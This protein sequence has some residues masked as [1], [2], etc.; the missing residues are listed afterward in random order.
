MRRC[1]FV[2]L[3]LSLG[4]RALGAAEVTIVIDSPM[5]PPAWALLEQQLLRANS[6]A[7]DFFFNK[8]VDERGYLL[9]TP[10]WGTI[11]DGPDDAIETFYNWTL[12]HALGG[13]DSVLRNFKKALDGHLLQYKEVKSTTTDVAKDGSYSKEFIV[14][15][16]WGHTGEGTR[17]FMLQGLS[18]PKD[19]V[20]R[21]RMRRFAGMYM[22]EDPD[23]QNYDPQHKV[24]K[25]IWNGSKGPMLR[26]ATKDDWVGDPIS[27]RFHMLHSKA[28][29][30][31]M[32]DFEEHYPKMLAHVEEYLDSAGDH[33]RNLAATNLALN[34]Y[35]LTHA[36]KYKD[37]L[38]EYVNAW[39][40][41][42]EANGGN[43]PTNVGLDGTLGGEH[44]GRW[45][46]GVYGW[47]FTIYDGEIER[48]DH[49]GGLPSRGSW[50][51]FGNALLLTGDQAYVDTLRRQID[52]L[53]AQQKVVDDKITVPQMY[54]D[55][56]GYRYSGPGEWYHW[57]PN[58]PVDEMTQIYLWSMD[59]KDLERIPKT[60]WVGFL[61]GQNPG[62]PEQA[63]AEDLEELRSRMEG[64]R[65][66]PTTPDTRLADWLQTG[67]SPAQTNALT[68]LMLGGYLST[69]RIWTLHS[70]VR[71]FDPVRRRSGPPED[72]GAL[73]QRLT[74][75][76]VT[77]TLVNTDQVKPR[78]VIVQAGGY[79]EHRFLSA[80]LNGK[81]V[82]IDHPYVTVRL[83]PGSGSQIEFKMSRY[84]NQPSLAHPWD[85]GWE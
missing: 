80:L 46:K 37:W 67:L 47:N 69:S 54:G 2:V 52:N 5:P 78:T 14:M 7:C 62:Y 33:P 85:R 48:I 6:G 24:I 65:D 10:R 16:D 26:K 8:Y 18:D 60:D 11:N 31:E 61:E 81:T 25:S 36:A 50:I 4:L 56:R 20:F 1:S 9:H 41:R 68:N 17:G 27:G 23:A 72:V 76:S 66:D 84:V 83:E 64:I 3:L 44:N 74:A 51:G 71:Y 15:S 53:Y 21:N 70:R 35:M 79:A 58:L 55:P 38:L 40:E 63:L 57:T 22:N 77:V 39:K 34:A 45:W 73:V 28:R 32:L 59:R 75:D 29:R 42:L 13:S 19:P 43:I 82:P 12:L 49:R 30:G